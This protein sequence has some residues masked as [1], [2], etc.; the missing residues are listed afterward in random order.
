[1]KA[2]RRRLVV[3]IVAGG[4]LFLVNN[5]LLARFVTRLPGGTAVAVTNMATVALV[6][7]A[8]RRFGAITL[9]YATYGGLGFLGHLGVDGLAYLGRLPMLLA[10]AIVFD[11]IVAIGRYRWPGLM[12]GASAFVLFVA[13]VLRS[14]PRPLV[15]LAALGLAYAGLAIGAL[16][17][18]LLQGGRNSPSAGS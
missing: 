2:S 11:S 18:A 7:L 3:P 1:M 12:L 5:V 10:A 6:V 4:V 15:V 9:I 14:S 16:A 13:V 8:T 17:H